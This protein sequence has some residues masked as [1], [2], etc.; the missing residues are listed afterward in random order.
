MF[1]RIESA[2]LALHRLVMLLAPQCY[3]LG[4]IS[5]LK[6]TILSNESL[7]C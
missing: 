2:A 4:F 7:S 3:T 6:L 1:F 5:E